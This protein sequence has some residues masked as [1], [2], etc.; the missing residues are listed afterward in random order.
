[1]TDA[2][3]IDPA[4]YATLEQTGDG[5]VLRFSRRLAHPR[6]AVW[7]A[8]TE[9]DHLAAWFPTT[10]EGELAPGASLCFRHRDE[11]LPPF[12]GEMIAVDPPAL[13]ELRWGPDSLRLRLSPNAPDACVLV[14][15]DTLDQLGKGARDA[16]G[17]H[18]CLDLLACDLDKRPAP[19]SSAQRWRQVSGEYIRR[20]GAQAA[21]VGPPEGWERAYGAVESSGVP[22][23]SS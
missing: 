14:F 8:L 4:D 11:V 3:D 22:R 6:E 10:I 9:E 1:M 18:A 15:T 21:T 16:A 5:P 13:I 12:G 2:N 7:R 17:W 23:T 20:F 19:W